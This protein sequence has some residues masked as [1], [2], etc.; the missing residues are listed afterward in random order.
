M[1]AE[2]A[3]VAAF[4][5][6]PLPSQPAYTGRFGVPESF[7]E[8][9]QRDMEMSYRALQD[10]LRLLEVRL[11]KLEEQGRQPTRPRPTS[12]RAAAAASAAAAAVIGTTF[13]GWW[14]EH[15]DDDMDNHCLACHRTASTTLPTVVFGTD[16]ALYSHLVD[17]QGGQPP[18]R[19]GHN[20][21]HSGGSG[22]KDA[23]SRSVVHP[24]PTP[25]SIPS[26]AVLSAP[27][28]P[29]QPVMH[30]SEASC[31]SAVT[32]GHAVRQ[33]RRRGMEGLSARRCHDL[34]AHATMPA[35]HWQTSRLSTS[36]PSSAGVDG[37]RGRGVVSSPVAPPVTR[38]DPEVQR[39]G[40]F[41]FNTNSEKLEKPGTLENPDKSEKLGASAG[42]GGGGAGGGGASDGG[43]GGARLPLAAVTAAARAGTTVGAGAGAGG[44]FVGDG[45][46]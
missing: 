42:D 11:L 30:P 28:S 26:S 1:P 34:G 2:E 29:A 15:A 33:R 9:L 8:E 6:P 18:Q 4:E 32:A 5:L 21:C 23:A 27:G 43:G 39:P 3:A 10:A 38:H 12:A 7:L 25:P 41:E 36:R 37:R 14:G 44:G 22:P 24:R 46:V 40:V 35:V 20:Q 13:D 31:G 19:G 16:G 45:E 17:E